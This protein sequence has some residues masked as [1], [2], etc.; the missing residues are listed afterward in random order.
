MPGSDER[1]NNIN[2]VG[3]ALSEGR[4]GV[5]SLPWGKESLLPLVLHLPSP[6]HPHKG[7]KNPIYSDW[8]QE[9]AWK[10]RGQKAIFHGTKPL[11]WSC[12]DLPPLPLLQSN[13]C[14]LNFV[15]MQLSSA[16]GKP[17]HSEW[18]SPQQFTPD[19]ALKCQR[20]VQLLNCTAWADHPLNSPS[21]VFFLSLAKLKRPAGLH[22]QSSRA[23]SEEREH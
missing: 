13:Q 15:T 20:E 11:Q 3:L 23:A 16:R 17:L 19:S 7:V 12:F 5:S 18:S 10:G 14:Q 2:I 21:L 4:K 22:G 1:P 8:S 9:L 6:F